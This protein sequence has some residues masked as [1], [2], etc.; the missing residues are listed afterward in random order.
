MV[1]LFR[2]QI[3]NL[4]LEQEETQIKNK[5]DFYDQHS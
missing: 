2:N 1:T 3:E 4:R 5:R